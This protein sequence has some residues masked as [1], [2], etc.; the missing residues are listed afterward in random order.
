MAP[1]S[2]FLFLSET[3]MLTAGVSDAGR[4][5]DVADEVFRL[6]H[7]GD[8]VMGGLDQNSHGLALVFPK[9]SPFPQMPVAG[10][11]RRFSAMPAYLG[12]RFDLC[13]VKWYGSN[14]ANR[15]RNLPRSILTLMLNDKD[16]GEPLALMSA[17]A[18][19]ASRTAAV[20]AVASR[21]LP[22][23]PP[24]TLAVIGCGVINRAIVR[25]LL[26]QHPGIERVVC[27]NRTTSTAHDFAG[28][29]QDEYGLD[30]AVADT[31]RECVEL[32]DIV[33]VAASRTAPLH[34]EASWF[35]AHACILLSGPMSADTDLWTS[36]R[37]VLDHVPLHESY[38]ND[39]RRSEDVSASFAAQIGG[40]VYEL[41]DAGLLPPLAR[42]EDLGGV[43][44][45]DSAPHPG[46]TVFIASG[47]AVFDVAWGSDLLRTARERGIGT[48]LELWGASPD[49]VA[50]PATEGA[51]A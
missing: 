41:I 51:S 38:V 16:T 12:G 6:L 17:G 30:T 32:A 5:V 48:E 36:S 47:M 10:P 34:L 45:A 49:T 18:L 2:P 24:R 29:L 3:D 4:S 11:D 15:E 39:A 26:S 25:A 33:S 27:H 1:Y 31:A 28:W 44:A 9:W 23:R 42:F 14:A 21:Y 40:P 50:S 19:S 13:G 35:T 37:I 7:T 20:P 43:I 22:A 46:R 8:Y